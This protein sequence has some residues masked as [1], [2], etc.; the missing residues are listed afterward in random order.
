[1]SQALLI[2]FVALLGSIHCSAM[3]CPVQGFHREIW[4]FQ[5]GRL[6]GYSALWLLIRLF[7]WA[8]FVQYGMPVFIFFAFFLTMTVF[9]KG[10]SLVGVPIPSVHIL[11]PRLVQRLEPKLRNPFLSGAS[12]SLRG[13]GWMWSFLALAIA[14]SDWIL[15]YSKLLCFYFGTLA[16]FLIAP[17]L[18]KAW[19]LGNRGRGLGLILL[20]IF[21]VYLVFGNPLEKV[22][23]LQT[24]LLGQGVKHPLEALCGPRAQ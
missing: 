20:A 14:E 13:C 18:P 5:V 15:S 11:P 12:L 7:S 3:C 8:L 22:Y 6:L 2:F 1:M 21:Q 17:I 4:K 9:L 24:M 10:L 19:A 23:T 16:P